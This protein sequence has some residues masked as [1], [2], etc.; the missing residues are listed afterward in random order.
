MLLTS[1]HFDLNKTNRIFYWN[2]GNNHSPFISWDKICRSKSNGGL[3]IRKSDLMNKA[4]QMKLIWKILTEPNN[5]WVNIIK[6]KYLKMRTSLNTRE[7][8]KINFGNGHK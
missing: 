6:E 3:S 1:I 5:I 2:K 4:L 7:T 8:R